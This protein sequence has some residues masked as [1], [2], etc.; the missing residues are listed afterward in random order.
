MKSV[1]VIALFVIVIGSIV[2]CK[3]DDTIG[4]P[5][6]DFLDNRNSNPTIELGVLDTRYI[7]NLS[8]NANNYFWDL[9]NG[10]KATTEDVE[11][12]YPVAGIYTLKLKA[13]NKAGDSSV[14][15]KTVHVYDYV[16]KKIIIKDINL[17]IYT[18]NGRG[19]PTSIQYPWFSKVKMWIQIKRGLDSVQ[20]VLSKN[21]DIEAPLV[22]QSAEVNNVAADQGSPI[23]FL[24]D[25]KVVINI[26]QRIRDDGLLDGIGGYAFNVFVQDES[27][28]YLILTSRWVGTATTFQSSIAKKEF[29]STTYGEACRIVLSG[30]LELL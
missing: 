16:L 12:S 11:I 6:A 28:T 27:G 10:K 13:V 25:K 8:S 3:K 2:S 22:Y 30:D 15:S 24:V 4:K 9:G 26:P 23:Q 7:K 17:N 14:V 18:I 20:Y 1:K 19:Y 29:T 21:G 5:V